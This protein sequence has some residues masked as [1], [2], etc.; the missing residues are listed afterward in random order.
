MTQTPQN[1]WPIWSTDMSSSSLSSSIL[2]SSWFHVSRH[3]HRNDACTKL[4]ISKQLRCSD[5]Q[6]QWDLHS[7]A[8]LRAS[9]FYQ[10]CNSGW[11]E[12]ENP[13]LGLT[14][15]DLPLPSTHTLL[16]VVARGEICHCHP[17]TTL[18]ISSGCRSPS[19]LLGNY[20]KYS[21]QRALVCAWQV[22]HSLWTRLVEDMCEYSVPVSSSY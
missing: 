5:L 4:H 15:V 6:E 1:N 2:N 14:L 19:V 8:G 18:N 17:D 11:R 7:A 12:L 3:L 13:L 10:L 22:P 20:L 9:T 21:R 16:L